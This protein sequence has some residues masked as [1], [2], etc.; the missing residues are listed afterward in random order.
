M[1]W[2]QIIS[3]CWVQ[4]IA[5][6]FGGHTS[7]GF[8]WQRCCVSFSMHAYNTYPGCPDSCY[9]PTSHLPHIRKTAKK[10][11]ATSHMYLVSGGECSTH[12]VLNIEF[13]GRVKHWLFVSLKILAFSGYVMLMWEKLSTR[14][15][16]PE[17]TIFMHGRAWNAVCKTW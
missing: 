12:Q 16:L 7:S 11:W 17:F 14:L 5:V 15:D 4:W 8:S 13:V 9:K 2:S 1:S 10:Y 6:P 3:A